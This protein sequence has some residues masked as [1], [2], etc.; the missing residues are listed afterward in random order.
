MLELREII[1]EALLEARRALREALS[2]GLTGVESKGSFGDL[3]HKFDILTEKAIIDVIKKRIKRPYII[4]EEI[5]YLPCEDPELY[6]LIDPV[7]GSNNVAHGLPFYAS[8]IALSKSPLISDVLAA[9]VIDHATGKLYIGDKDAG[10]I[11]DGR[12]PSMSTVRSLQN[13]LVFADLAS[14]KRE[15][16]R[17]DWCTKIITGARHVRFFGAASLEIA[18]IL[19]GKADAFACIS[20]DSKIMDFCASMYLVKWAGGYYSIIDGDENVPMTEKKR[21]GVVIASTK[22]LLEEILSLKP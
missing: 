17:R 18:Y 2:E 6:V 14:M 22:E 5:G 19:D 21:L 7:D 16:S 1:K 10:V 20:R 8:S 4:S 9:G 13:A 3:S 11:V 15:S 12:P